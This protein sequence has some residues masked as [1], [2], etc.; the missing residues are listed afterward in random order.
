ME[1]M[2]FPIARW[3]IVAALAGWGGAFA[4]LRFWKPQER[5]E[6]TSKCRSHILHICTL[7]AILFAL[8]A[9]L[10]GTA[11]QIMTTSDVVMRR[12]A[13][14]NRPKDVSL[15]VKTIPYAGQ[16]VWVT[17]HERWLRQE[18]DAEKSAKTVSDYV[19]VEALYT[20]EAATTGFDL[21][22]KSSPDYSFSVRA[23]Y[24]LVSGGR[25][26]IEA[27]RFEK[28]AQEVAVVRVPP[29]E[30]GDTVALVAKVAASQGRVPDDVGR[31]LHV[32]AK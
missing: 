15:T 32:Y 4:A 26:L 29:L 3:F 18:A 5:Y 21:I 9:G 28:Q 2:W 27:V 25:R 24:R 30:K 16:E 31:V 13:I 19:V 20:T 10:S 14:R 23:V 12:P 17:D 1:S 8:V 22:L 6:I 7:Y 11:Y